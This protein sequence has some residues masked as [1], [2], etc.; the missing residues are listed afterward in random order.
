MN[1]IVCAV[2][3]SP[4]SAQ[5]ARVAARLGETL[6]LRLVL[7]HVAR[8]DRLAG[9]TPAAYKRARGEAERLLDRVKADAGLNGNA[10]RRAEAGGDPASTIARVAAE[11]AASLIV[12]GARSQGRRRRTLLSG[13]AAELNATAPCPVLVV[14]P[15]AR[16]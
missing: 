11:E 7:A 3:E 9:G 8:G 4:G 6:G 1:T 12:V 14:P 2:D 5:A 10:D 16:R 15:A 13:L